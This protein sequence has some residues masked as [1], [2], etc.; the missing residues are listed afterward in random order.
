MELFIF[1]A[2][3]SASLIISLIV[4]LLIAYKAVVLNVGKPSFQECSDR[5]WLER[6]GYFNVD[7]EAFSDI[8]TDVMN[9]TSLD[10]QEARMAVLNRL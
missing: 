2:L 8:V 4:F 7:V 6:R 5:A 10:V 3:L 9:A 1:S